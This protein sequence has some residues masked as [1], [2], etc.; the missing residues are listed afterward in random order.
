MSEQGKSKLRTSIDAIE[1][2][3]EFMLAYAAQG[4]DFEYTGGGAGPSIRG[5]LGGLKDGLGSIADDFEAEVKENVKS[6]AE[7]FNQFIEI[8][9]ADAQKSLTAV[10]MVLSLPSIGSQVVDNLNASIHIRAM[11]T[12]LFLIDEALSSLKRQE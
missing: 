12:D 2:G 6:G 9:R 3:Y 10:S 8:L 11:L 5:Y 4:R 1:G 7:E